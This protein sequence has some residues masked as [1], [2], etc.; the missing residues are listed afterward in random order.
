MASFGVARNLEAMVFL[1]TFQ[2]WYVYNVLLKVQ[3]FQTAKL[4]LFPHV[5]NHEVAKHGMETR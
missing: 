4:A 5:S 3:L 1:S 2:S